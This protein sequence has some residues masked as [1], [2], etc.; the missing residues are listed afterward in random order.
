MFGVPD[1]SVGRID[2][3]GFRNRL[4]AVLAILP[5]S[6]YHIGWGATLQPARSHTSMVD[7]VSPVC[8][9]R[10]EVFAKKM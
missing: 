10:T 8:M 1:L 9:L 4:V 2:L 3:F 6:A 5:T 7:S